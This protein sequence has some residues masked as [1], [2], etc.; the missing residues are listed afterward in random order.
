LN[1]TQLP[2]FEKWQSASAEG[3]FEDKGQQ[4]FLTAAGE[5]HCARPNS[6]SFH[7]RFIL[8]GGRDKN[9]NICWTVD[10]YQKLFKFILNNFIIVG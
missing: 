5:L 3:S 2:Q 9:F 6:S 8:S 1:P 4:W 7:V 10:N